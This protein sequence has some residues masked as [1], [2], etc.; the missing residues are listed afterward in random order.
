MIWIS[1]PITLFGIFFIAVKNLWC[2]KIQYSSIALLK[3]ISCILYLKRKTPVSRSLFWWLYEFFRDIWYISKVFSFVYVF[4]HNFIK[5][6]INVLS[7]FYYI[8]IKVYLVLWKE[9]LRIHH[10]NTDNHSY[11]AFFLYPYYRVY[12]L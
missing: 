2:K 11:T 9:A 3:S 6:K 7:L 12:I 10:K 8:Q 1:L 4:C 5:Q